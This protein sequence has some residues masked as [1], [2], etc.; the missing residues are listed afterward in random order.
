MNNI[1]ELAEYKDIKNELSQKLTDYLQKTN[2]PR[3]T[4]Q[5]VNW[6]NLPYYGR[7][8]WETHPGR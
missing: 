3:E 5:E 2:D 8:D 4:N 7:H 6:D 1:A